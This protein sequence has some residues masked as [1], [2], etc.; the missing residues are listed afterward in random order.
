MHR[1]HLFTK[2]QFDTGSEPVDVHCRWSGRTDCGV[3][4]ERVEIGIV[5]DEDI[6]GQV[7]GIQRTPCVSCSGVV[8]EQRDDTIRDAGSHERLDHGGKL[9]G[10]ASGVGGA[11]VEK[12]VV[13]CQMW[14]E[15]IESAAQDGYIG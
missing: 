11:E 9:C 14:I 3:S 2:I 7:D 5:Q 15:Q 1:Q 10:A 12:C 13:A 4:A 6:R 8:V